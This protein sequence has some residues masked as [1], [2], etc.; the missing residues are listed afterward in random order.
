M[1][2]IIYEPLKEAKRIKIFIP[3][4][5]IVIREALKKM[6]SSFWHPHQKLWSVIN[7]D[8][9]FESLK[10]LCHGNYKIEKAGSF[11]CCT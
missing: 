8:D 5:M 11:Y 10:K 6:N 3:Y 2:P 4:E 1:Q 7:T 9:N